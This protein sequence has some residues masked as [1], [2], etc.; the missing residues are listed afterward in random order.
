[1]AQECWPV[2]APEQDVRGSES[3]RERNI[4]RDVALARHAAWQKK[5]RDVRVE[6]QAHVWLSADDS[7]RMLADQV[8]LPPQPD[9]LK[10]R[11]KMAP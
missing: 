1:M 6:L 9:L 2:Y 3:G 5:Q 4:V 7:R 11:V 10:S 8:R